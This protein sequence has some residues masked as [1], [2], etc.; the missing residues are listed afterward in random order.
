[1]AEHDIDVD[2]VIEEMDAVPQTRERR[3][4]R[5]LAREVKA[6]KSGTGKPKGKGAGRSSDQGQDQ[7]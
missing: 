7:G 4:I 1:M 2:R 3:M 6:I 5:A